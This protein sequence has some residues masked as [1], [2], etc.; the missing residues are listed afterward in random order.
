MEIKI[1]NYYYCFDF[2]SFVLVFKCKLTVYKRSHDN[3]GS[4]IIV[5]NENGTCQKS[6]VAPGQPHSGHHVALV[7]RMCQQAST[8]HSILF[9]NTLS[10]RIIRKSSKVLKNY[11]YTLFVFFFELD[12][13]FL[14]NQQIMLNFVLKLH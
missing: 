5:S 11:L 12:N 1:I 10:T 14:I 3:Q 2:F 13:T 6:P 9:Q 8:W 7:D 4:F